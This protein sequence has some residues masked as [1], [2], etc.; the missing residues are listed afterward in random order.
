M[1]S[2]SYWWK[3]TLFAAFAAAA[4]GGTF[5]IVV[6]IGGQA[7]GVALDEPRGV[8][9]I[10]NFTANRIDVMSLSNCAIQTSTNV[11]AQQNAGSLSR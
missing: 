9:Y 7:S 6:P 5:G 10:A 1:L 4:W 11:A 8:L 2:K 3:S